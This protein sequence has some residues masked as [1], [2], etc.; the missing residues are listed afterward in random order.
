MLGDMP[1][2]SHAYQCQDCGEQSFFNVREAYASARLRCT[3]CGSLWVKFHTPPPGEAYVKARLRERR[4]DVASPAAVAARRV[5]W[6]KRAK[7]QYDAKR[8][9][10]ELAAKVHAYRNGPLR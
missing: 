10:E 4:R 7:A 5:A 2:K 3:K 8:M 1:S 9:R 6:L